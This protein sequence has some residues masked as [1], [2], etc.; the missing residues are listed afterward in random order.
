MREGGGQWPS[1]P[2]RH[3]LPSSTSSHF[4]SVPSAPSL[5]IHITSQYKC[6]KHG[7]FMKYVMQLIYVVLGIIPCAPISQ[8]D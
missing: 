6:D 2:H 8:I 3:L 7:V 5:P 1:A 4:S